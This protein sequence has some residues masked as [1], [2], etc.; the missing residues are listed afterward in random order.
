VF[1]CGLVRKQGSSLRIGATQ[2][3]EEYKDGGEL[4]VTWMY[5]ICQCTYGNKDNPAERRSTNSRGS[6][7]PTHRPDLD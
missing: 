5:A 6:R 4:L 1:V 3:R 7:L 2:Y